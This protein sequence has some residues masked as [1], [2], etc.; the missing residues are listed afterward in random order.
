MQMTKW[1]L[2]CTRMPE[3]NQTCILIT[4]SDTIEAQAEEYIVW[5]AKYRGNNRFMVTDFDSDGIYD[6][7]LAPIC[8]SPLPKHPFTED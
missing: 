5:V 8:W 1:T 2:C 4:H 6:L 3:P 7:S